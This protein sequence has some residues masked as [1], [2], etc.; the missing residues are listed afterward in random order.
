MKRLRYENYATRTTLRELCY[1]KYATRT[2]KG[3]TVKKPYDMPM[4]ALTRIRQHPAMKQ[5]PPAENPSPSTP[6]W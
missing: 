6:E 1:E 5:S 4:L 2:M 3:A